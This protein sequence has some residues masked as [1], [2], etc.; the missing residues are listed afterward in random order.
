M[1]KKKNPFPIF[2]A[3]S[4]LEV[5]PNQILNANQEVEYT[6][7]KANT[8]KMASPYGQLGFFSQKQNLCSEHGFEKDIQ[9]NEHI[10]QNHNYL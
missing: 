6:K 7:I 8:T 4:L 9:L 5:L 10:N 1:G 2:L 3:Y